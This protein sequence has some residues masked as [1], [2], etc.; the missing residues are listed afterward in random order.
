MQNFALLRA[1]GQCGRPVLLK[2]GM[3]SRISEWLEAGEHLLCA[4]S[5][6]VIFCERGIIGF[7]PSTRNLLDLA[8][9]A[10][11][12]HVH[13][14]PI[15][16]DPSHAVGKR[17]L[18][19]PL[20]KAALA[21]GADGLLIECHPEPQKARSDAAQALHPSALSQLLNDDPHQSVKTVEV[22]A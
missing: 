15:V 18:I 1:V 10:Q 11:M 13:G 20:A 8:A 2:R 4:G 21:A 6:D 22:S 7:D 17:N 9:V 12:K 16:V 5:S 3:A 14:L 19:L